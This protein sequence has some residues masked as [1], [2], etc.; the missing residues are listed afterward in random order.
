MIATW[1][2]SLA[3]NE[4]RMLSAGALVATLLLLWA[5]A[6]HPLALRRAELVTDVERQRLE[7]AEVRSA[8]ADVA[9]L[10]AVGAQARGDREGKS[11]L[12]LADTTAR[13]AGLGS[14]LR[15]VEPVGERDV[16][17]AFEGAGFDPLVAWLEQLAGRHG[18]EAIE[19][20]AQRAQGIGLV[21]AHVT[22]RDAP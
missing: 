16:R 11:L 20:S 7:L 10:R 2:Q 14:A 3:T 19:F 18:I 5:F 21:D 22:L 15:R 6:W 4:R 8:A 1:W 17:V 9:R 12:A 13:E